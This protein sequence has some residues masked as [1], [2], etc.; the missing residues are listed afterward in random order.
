MLAGIRCRVVQNT[1]I[2]KDILSDTMFLLIS[3]SKSTP[4]QNRQ[5]GILMIDGNQNV[6]DFGA[7]VDFLRL[8]NQCTL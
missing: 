7:G 3:F 1:A 6:D 4:Q 2:E 5:V 8:I